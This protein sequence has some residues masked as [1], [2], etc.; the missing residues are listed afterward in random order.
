MKPQMLAAVV[1]FSFFVPLS[2]AWAQRADLPGLEG[3][4]VRLPHA[5]ANLLKLHYLAAIFTTLLVE[6]TDWRLTPSIALRWLCGIA[7][8]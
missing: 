1:T 5:S 2:P 7:C 4:W 6:P 3:I 8:V